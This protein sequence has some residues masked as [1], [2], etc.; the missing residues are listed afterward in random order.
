MSALHSGRPENPIIDTYIHDLRHLKRLWRRSPAMPVAV[1]ISIAFA[2]AMS[3]TIFSLVNTVALRPLPFPQPHRVV[4]LSRVLPQGSES[5]RVAYEQFRF[6][7]DRNSV[8]EDVAAIRSQPY[9][10]RVGDEHRSVNA[11]V[12]SASFF[13]V[14]AAEPLLGRQ[15]QPNDD[16]PGAAPVVVLNETTWRSVFGADV[17]ILGQTV[18]LEGRRER[19]TDHVIVG[20]ARADTRLHWLPRPSVFL[21]DVQDEKHFDPGAVR[22]V[23][24]RLKPGI[25]LET[26][27]TQFTELIR[28]D[29]YP[30]ENGRGVVTPL[31]EA[32]FGEVWRRLRI[33][34]VAVGL[35]L[36]LAFVN[37]SVLLLIS[38]AERR[39]ELATR[40]ALGATSFRLTRVLLGE[41][42]VLT[43]I[44]LVG[45][46]MLAWFAIRLVILLS[47]TD[48]PRIGSVRFDPTTFALS[49]AVAVLIGLIGTVPHLNIIRRVNLASCLVSS[50][51][52]GLE[53]PHRLRRDGLLLLQ[54]ALVLALVVNAALALHSFWRLSTVEL[55]F[56]PARVVAVD[57]S[58]GTEY[59]LDAQKLKDVQA[60]ILRDVRTLS[61]V[62]ATALATNLPTTLGTYGIPLPDGRSLFL[63]NN[64][65]TADYFRLLS[66]P[67]L[68]GR[69]LTETDDDYAMVVNESFVKQFLSGA[70]A[71][72]TVLGASGVN[73]PRLI[74]GVVGDT[75]T[76]TPLQIPGRARQR[77]TPA[78]TAVPPPITYSRV[79]TNRWRQSAVWLLVRARP[80]VGDVQEHVGEVIRRI[81]PAIAPEFRT[82]TDEVD[83][84]KV[85]VRFYAV[86]LGMVASVGLL[87][88]VIGVAAAARQVAVERLREIGLRLALGASHS[89]VTW[90]LLRRMVAVTLAAA[91]FGLYAG[92]VSAS[93][94]RTVLF[95]M[96]ASNTSTLLAAALALGLTVV[97]AAYGPLRRASRID[98]LA[99]L[100]TD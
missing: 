15:L 68:Q 11:H 84:T 87:L 36:L 97:G 24:A 100:R 13:G 8:F 67:T 14:L 20:V 44:G 49:S 17:G 16:R 93:G 65:V 18:R 7:R 96:E 5:S 2:V 32:E 57:M 29:P 30:V 52:I 27:S 31:H 9:R 99:I 54:L 90:L 98:P 78:R 38:A 3:T 70:S 40:M 94:L 1:V 76:A 12:V 62:E 33:L 21:P 66:I 80:G 39:R 89:S 82:L 85:P 47:P 4:V 26:A 10:M 55:G 73:A 53:R 41:Q 77:L 71:V 74:V 91:L 63:P 46:G 45:G 43:T 75:W 37:I 72:G 48:V 81:D 19:G 50:A 6:W 35:V 88:S 86:L 51:V 92:V 64:N 34:V 60:R 42:A 83:L 79:D 58:L 28:R 23:I 59:E 69:G 95:D 22:E 56:D 61:E 25:P